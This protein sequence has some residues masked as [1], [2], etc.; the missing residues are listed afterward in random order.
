MITHK[1][2]QMLSTAALGTG[3]LARPAGRLAAAAACA[4]PALLRHMS[5]ASA[6]TGWARCAFECCAALGRVVGDVASPEVRAQRWPGWP[7]SSFTSSQGVPHRSRKAGSARQ[8]Q[9]SPAPPLP[10]TVRPC[11]GGGGGETRPALS[12]LQGLKTHAADLQERFCELHSRYMQSTY[13]QRDP[14]PAAQEWSAL[15]A[16]QV[17]WPARLSWQRSHLRAG[18]LAALA[19]RGADCPLT[20]SAPNPPEPRTQVRAVSAEQSQLRKVGPGRGTAEALRAADA[21]HR[22]LESSLSDI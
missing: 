16:Q 13:S 9:P 15:W 14:R 22:E 4:L 11:S 10:P 12:T 21:A 20:H 8:P 5:A 6:A 2:V 7:P 1:H 18:V 19:P 3:S 17:R